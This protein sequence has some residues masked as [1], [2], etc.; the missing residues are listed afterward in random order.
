[1]LQNNVISVYEDKRLEYKM[2]NVV[3]MPMV[4]DFIYEEEGLSEESNFIS[5]IDLPRI[6]EAN[7]K[8]PCDK[9]DY[10]AGLL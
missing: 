6:T 9:C 4:E 5:I 2:E 3:K 7:G 8:F 1:M 10:K